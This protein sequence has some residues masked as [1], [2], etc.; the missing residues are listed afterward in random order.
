M[1]K[2]YFAFAVASLTLSSS[3]ALAAKPGVLA[4]INDREITVDEFNKRFEQNSKLVPGKTPAK[5]E[6]LKNIIYFE[7]ATQEAR[8]IGLHKENALKEQF[9][10]LL[11]QA[12]V[13]KNVQPKVDAIQPSDA[14]VRQYYEQNPLLR[15]SHIVF[16]SRPD[17]SQKDVQDLRARAEQ[18]LAEVKDK[19][20]SFEDLARKHSEGPNAKAGG[21]VDWGSRH[22]L[23]PEYYDAALALKN[24]GDTS[25]IVETPYGFHIIKLTGKMAYSDK[26]DPV[27]KD[28]IIR[29]IR[30]QKGQKVFDEYFEELK[31][32][33][34][35]TVN[36]ELLK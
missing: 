28:F 20:A 10:I 24:V 21:D 30:E 34:R 15:T 17:M 22:K 18:V 4:K 33:A 23:L 32:K 1:L 14:E 35:V 16:L 5:D 19:K 31:K 27:Y 3:V 25:G 26:V 6:V 13:R 7:L 9:D 29:T 36:N 8:R 2:K 12:L 11:Y